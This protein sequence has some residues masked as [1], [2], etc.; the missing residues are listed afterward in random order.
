LEEQDLKKEIMAIL[1]DL[2]D[3]EKSPTFDH[4]TE[5]C[6]WVENNA[7]ESYHREKHFG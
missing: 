1:T 7:G 3:T 2:S 6:E 5:Q 4:W